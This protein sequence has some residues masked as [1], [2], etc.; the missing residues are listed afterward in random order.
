MVDFAHRRNQ[1]LHRAQRLHRVRHGCS[2]V[3]ERNVVGFTEIRAIGAMNNLPV[4]GAQVIFVDGEKGE[5]YEVHPGARV[6]F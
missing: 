2:L 3:L 6:V 4:F 1:Q 5:P